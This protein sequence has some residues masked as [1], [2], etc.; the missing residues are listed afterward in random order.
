[1]I[2]ARPEAAPRPA[3]ECQGIDVFF[4]SLAALRE[5]SL[6]L[7]AGRIHA[8]VGQN[9]A[10][11]TT[12]ARVLGGLLEARAGRVWVRGQE[13]VGGDVRAAQEAGLAMVH[14]QFS[15]PPSFTVAEALELAAGRANTRSVYRRAELERRWSAVLEGA[16]GVL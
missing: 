15:L 8:L 10:G 7:G 11:K 9:G 1:M 13:I 12:L 6:E 14:Q 2:T 4:G 16:E 5:V 3:I